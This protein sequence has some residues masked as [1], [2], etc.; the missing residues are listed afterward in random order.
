VLFK[1][2]DGQWDHDPDYSERRIYLVGDRKTVEN[3][4]KFVRDI[5]TDA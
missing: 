3:M 4:V 1:G 2:G 5:K